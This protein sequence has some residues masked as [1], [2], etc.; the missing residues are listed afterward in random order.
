MRSHFLEEGLSSSQEALLIPRLSRSSISESL[1]SMSAPAHLDLE[2][3]HGALKPPTDPIALP[4]SPS[5]KPV[6][7]PN[8]PQQPS[9]PSKSTTHLH[10]SQHRPLSSQP[11]PS[12]PDAIPPKLL[13]L[14][15]VIGITTPPS[16]LPTQRPAPNLGIY[17]RIIHEERTAK[18]QFYFAASVINVCYFGQIC[19]AAALTA[20][21]ASGSSNVAITVLGAA[22]TVLAGVLTYLK[23]QGLPTRLRHYWTALR[24]CREFIEEVE[25][26][27]EAEEMGGVGEKGGKEEG[28][29]VEGMIETIVRMY[30]DVRQTAEDNTPDTYIPMQGSSAAALSS[31]SSSRPTNPTNNPP[32]T[33]EKKIRYPSSPSTEA[34]SEEEESGIEGQ[35]KPIDPSP[36]PPFVIEQEPRAQPEATTTKTTP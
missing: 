9:N 11:S 2:R 7:S 20:L 32:P 6:P 24:K 22:N 8:N 13:K 33:A 23:G 36:S 5:S 27:V 18:F 14:R 26:E 29:D 4:L 34:T 17:T 15:T 35:K 16:L 3:G 30:H 21:G 10:Q 12:D 28:V 31:S 25:R 1:F 19:I